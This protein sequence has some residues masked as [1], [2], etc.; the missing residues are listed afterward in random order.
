MQKHFTHLNLISGINWIVIKQTAM[1][2]TAYKYVQKVEGA[3]NNGAERWSKI[4][5]FV[6]KWDTGAES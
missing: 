3:W 2:A 6:S 4:K 1:D 5:Q